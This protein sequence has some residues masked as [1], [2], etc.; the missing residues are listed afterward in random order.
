M[1]GPHLRAG[2]RVRVLRRARLA[3]RRPGEPGQ[4]HPGRAA[5]APGAHDAPRSSVSP[6]LGV[7]Y[8]ITERAGLHFAY[9]HFYQYPGA[10]RHLHQRRLL[11]P[12]PPAGGTRDHPVMGNPDIKPERTVQYE[13]GY[14][15]ALTDDLGVDAQRLLQGHPR[16]ARR[17]VHRDLQRRRV[18]PADERRLR[19]RHRLHRR[20]RPAAARPVQP[21]ARLHLAARPGELE[22]PAARPRRG[23]RRARTRGRGGPVQ[24]GPAAHAQPDAL[25]LAQP[26]AYSTSAIV[27]VASGQ[28]YTPVLAR[29]S[30]TGSSTNSGRKPASVRGGP[31]RRADPAPGGPQRVSLFG[32]VFNLFDTRFFNGIVF[33]STGSPYYSRFP[34]AGRG[35]RWPTRP[36]TTR[37][38]GS[39]SASRVDSG[40]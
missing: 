26:G 6:R 4:L 38:G 24:L 37:R 9:G 18:R 28:P 5:V 27:R 13:F 12:R 14:K 3:A 32:R 35:A 36:G 19:R 34:G 39:R 17:R 20:A 29:A 11:D 16:P 1:E 2:L 8:P 31:A 30:A 15:Q 21:R 33:D 25:A 23:P 10:R 22:R 40:W 7:A